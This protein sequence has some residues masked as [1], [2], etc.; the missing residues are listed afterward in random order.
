M[1]IT[2][3]YKENPSADDLKL[4]FDGISAE[5][6][7]KRGLLKGKSFC[8]FCKDISGKVVGGVYG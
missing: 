3:A 8:F 1:T 5:A 2:T 7:L 4:L 6:Y